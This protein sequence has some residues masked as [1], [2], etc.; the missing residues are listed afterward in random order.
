M[1]AA[2]SLPLWLWGCRKMCKTSAVEGM[3]SAD[4]WCMCLCRM[5]NRAQLGEQLC[6][7]ASVWLFA[8]SL[9]F[10]LFFSHVI[11]LYSLS[12]SLLL[13]CCT[14]SK[15]KTLEIVNVYSSITKY[16]ISLQALKLLLLKETFITFAACLSNFIS[17]YIILLQDSPTSSPLLPSQSHYW[18]VSNQRRLWVK[19]IS[20]WNAAQVVLLGHAEE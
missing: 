8:L 5:V 6:L 17:C 19:R 13:F 3:L 20:A 7:L 11:S 15:W 1:L 2:E 14:N 12:L 16:Y 18:N 9:M 10:L 4:A